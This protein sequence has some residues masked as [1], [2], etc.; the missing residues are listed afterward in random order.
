[1]VVSLSE[2]SISIHMMKLAVLKLVEQNCSYNKVGS[3]GNDAKM[4]EYVVM[5]HAINIT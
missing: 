3:S 5:L 1:M 2:S 4:F